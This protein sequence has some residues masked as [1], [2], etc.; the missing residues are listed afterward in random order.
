MAIRI[1]I[2][3]DHKIIRDGLRSLIERSPELELIGEAA[4]GQEAI[5]KADELL[6]DVVLIDI[7]M[8]VVEGSAATREILTR[9][10]GMKV[11][12]LSMH[13][14]RYFVDKMRAAGV[15]GYVPK[16]EAYDVLEEAITTVHDGGTF[17]HVG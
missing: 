12:T 2:A 8:P 10:P 7:T 11:L 13:T 15:S 14:D 9:H 16:D 17:F 5:D 4:D 6:P 1:L 3:D